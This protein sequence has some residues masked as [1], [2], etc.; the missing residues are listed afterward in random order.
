MVRGHVRRSGVRPERRLVFPYL[1][2]KEAF[3]LPGER[4]Q[5]VADTSLLRPNQR[6]IP[7][8]LR[9]QVRSQTGTGEH[10][11]RNVT[12]AHVRLLHIRERTS[13]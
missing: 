7:L 3:R 6:N 2:V 13:S 5:I 4:Q 8:H 9:L 1:I 11:G 12:S 10:P